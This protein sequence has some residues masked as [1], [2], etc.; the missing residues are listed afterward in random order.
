VP[1]R[2]KI[3]WFKVL[4]TIAHRPREFTET[5]NMSPRLYTIALKYFVS[6]GFTD[7]YTNGTEKALK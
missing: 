7:T 3:L 2:Y 1:N 5:S 4:K 6:S